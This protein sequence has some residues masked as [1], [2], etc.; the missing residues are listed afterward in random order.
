MLQ[1]CEAW[2]DHECPVT[3]IF[4]GLGSFF[5]PFGTA[6]A[7]KAPKNGESEVDSTSEAPTWK[8]IWEE[9]M[10]HITE[11]FMFWVILATQTAGVL[12]VVVARLGERSWGAT[13]FQ[14]TFF[15]CMLAVGL[16]TASAIYLQAGSWLLGAAT[17]GIMA[18]GATIDCSSDRSAAPEF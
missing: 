18:V 15:V 17:L 3:P 16:A 7:F 9:S 13:V 8:G 2:G 6:V 11:A 14:R 10:P 4:P 1:V 5:G 12:S